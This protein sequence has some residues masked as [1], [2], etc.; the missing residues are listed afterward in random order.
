MKS[1]IIAGVLVLVGCG[2]SAPAAQTGASTNGSQTYSIQLVRHP[3][4]G[5]RWTETDHLRATEEQTATQPGGQP[6]THGSSTEIQLVV[7]CEVLAL[8]AER[9]VSRLRVA[10]RSF[11]VDSG[12]GP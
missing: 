11:T 2:A 12:H 4:V 9:Q 5:A 6:E 7:D 1:E 10:I 8:D 3:P